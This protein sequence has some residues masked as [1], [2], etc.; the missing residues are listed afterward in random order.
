MGMVV[1]PIGF[2]A[3]LV[4]NGLIATV[5]PAAALVLVDV[6]LITEGESAT[7]VGEQFTLVPGVV[8]SCASGGEARVVAGA[9]GTVEAE[10]RL[11]NGLGPPRGDDTIAP[12]V[13]G[14]PNSVVPMV[15]ICAIQLLLPSK[16]TII[17][18]KIRTSIT[19]ASVGLVR[20]EPT[21]SGCG[22]TLAPSTRSTA[23]LRT[24]WSP[25]LMP[26]STTTCFP[27]SRAIE[28]FCR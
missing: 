17:A 14:I 21:G 10:K 12:G 7:A 9:P 2:I 18:K 6:T 28:I 3:G 1:A 8:G 24:T 5:E 13:V 4:P 23:G 19:P 15:D 11:V 20:H 27:R 25:D 16:N 22:A 26:C